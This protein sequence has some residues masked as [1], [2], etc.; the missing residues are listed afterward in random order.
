MSTYE[1]QVLAHERN[2]PLLTSKPFVSSKQ[3]IQAF[4]DIDRIPSQK[5]GVWSWAGPE[6]SKVK[7]ANNCFKFSGA[8]ATEEEASVQAKKI[9]DANPLFDVYVV[10]NFEWITL[11]CQPDI[12]GVIRHNYT[13]AIMQKIM[14]GRHKAIQ[15]GKEE[16]LKRYETDKKKTLE[17]L[18]KKYGPDYQ[19]KEKPA[20]V[21]EYDDARLLAANPISEE[22]KFSQTYMS[23]IATKFMLDNATPEL[24]TKFARHLAQ[25]IKE[26]AEGNA[27]PAAPVAPAPE[28]AA[29]AEPVK[30]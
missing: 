10:E 11:P 28:Q 3:C 17:V 6:G 30:A 24:A 20:Y 26:T 22:P 29:A 21:N 18:K 5:Y 2:G 12:K 1:K 13:D 15:L 27:Q 8:F 25:C 23:N 9:R 14:D 16:Q 7:S 4:G 19:M